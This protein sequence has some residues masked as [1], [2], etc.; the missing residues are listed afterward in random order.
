LD[1]LGDGASGVVY[2]AT[3]LSTRQLVAIKVLRHDV[4][5]A[6]DV[7][8]MRARFEREM[9]LCATL[10]HPHIVRL[11]DRGE[12]AEGEPFAV[13]E[14]VPGETLHSTLLREGALSASEAGELMGQ[15]L[16]ALVAAHAAGII[17]RDLK[18]HNIM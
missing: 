1:Q 2:R 4:H 12:S 5:Q 17:H 8:R 10:H 15:V 6:A 14:F 13:F 9:E 3:Q 11:L 7:V 18:P 16:D